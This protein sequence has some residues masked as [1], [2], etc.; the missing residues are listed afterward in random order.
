MGEKHDM[1]PFA[2][3]ARALASQIVAL[4]EE[5]KNGHC[6]LPLELLLTDADDRLVLHGETGS[7]G[8]LKPIGPD[9]ELRARFP[10]TATVTDRNGQRWEA[11]FHA[12]SVQ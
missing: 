8:V 9:F 4:L 11:I 1:N 6:T 10:V 5:A 2:D 3:I 7:D 12:P